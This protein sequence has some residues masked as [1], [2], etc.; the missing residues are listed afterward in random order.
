MAE[1]TFLFADLAGFTALTEAHGDEQA[2]DLA[3]RYFECVRSLLDEHR[4]TEVKTIGDA[5]M[6]HC[7]DPSTAICLGLAIVDT[8][9]EEPRFPTVRVGMHTGEAVERNGDWFGSAVNTAARVS[10]AAAD[11]EVLLSERTR[12]AA[13]PLEEIGFQRHGQ[14]Q[15]KNLPEPTLIHR[16]LRAGASREELPIDPVCRMTIAERSAAGRLVHDGVEYHF[17]SLACAAKFAEN[18]DAYVA[19]S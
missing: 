12:A 14:V 7:A 3:E 8:V 13:G 17:C 6:L 11:G 9:D 10:G 15:L 16:A 18:P 19:A 5:I 4:A 2:A 1:H